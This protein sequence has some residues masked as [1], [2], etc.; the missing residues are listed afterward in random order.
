MKEK[1]DEGESLAAVTRPLMDGGKQG[2]QPPPETRGRR[3]GGTRIPWGREK[4]RARETVGGTKKAWGGQQG[5]RAGKGG[6][7]TVCRG[8]GGAL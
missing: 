4:E 7:A 5:E 8:N 1:A 6:E 2:P 3:A